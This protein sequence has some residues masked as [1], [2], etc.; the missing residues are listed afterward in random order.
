MVTSL[1]ESGKEGQ[2]DY[3][4]GNIYHLVKNA[5]NR[6]VNPEIIGVQKII[7]V[8]NE[9]RSV[10]NDWNA[11]GRVNSGEDPCT[12]GVKLVGFRPD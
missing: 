12:S 3:I 5:E 1:K 8:I 11:D 2:F 6:P 10:L 9:F 4:L 7:W